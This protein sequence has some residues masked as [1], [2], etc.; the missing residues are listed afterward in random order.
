MKDIEINDD[1]N[2]KSDCYVEDIKK[3]LSYSGL[4]IIAMWILSFFIK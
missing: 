3:A 2:I 1:D 4:I